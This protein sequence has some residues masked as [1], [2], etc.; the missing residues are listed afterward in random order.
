MKKIIRKNRILIIII[1]I[2]MIF[3]AILM[4]SFANHKQFFI[5]LY[6]NRDFHHSLMTFSLIIS[7]FAFL[8]TVIFVGLVSNPSIKRL[9]DNGYLDGL[10]HSGVTEII[11]SC[12]L[13]MITIASILNIFDIEQHFLLF[14]TLVTLEITL[15]AG[16]MILFLYCVFELVFCIDTIRKSKK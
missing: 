13:V 4:F 14:K 11:I 6:N 9:W 12:V 10:Y 8:G 2:L 7:V 15:S 1:A 3:E 16:N 5:D